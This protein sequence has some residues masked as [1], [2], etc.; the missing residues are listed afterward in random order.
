MGLSWMER[1]RIEHLKQRKENLMYEFIGA[2]E[3]VNNQ[4]KEVKSGK[5]LEEMEKNE[6]SDM[7]K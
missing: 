2:C 6:K 1:K 7:G 5:W 3:E 4:I